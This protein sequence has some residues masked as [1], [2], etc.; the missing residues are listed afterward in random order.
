MDAVEDAHVPHAGP[1]SPTERCRYLLEAAEA[2]FRAGEIRASADLALE[3]SGLAIAM[4]RGDLAAAAA[5]VMPGV[6]DPSTA[7][8]VERMCRAALASADQADRGQRARIHA[9]LS[10][11]LHLR[12]RLDE[13]VDQADRAQVLADSIDDPGAF[14]AAL[15]A[16]LLAI[17][18]LGQAVEQLELSERMLD[19]AVAAASDD[20]ELQ[21]RIWRIDAVLR[22][23]RTTEAGHEV[24]SLDVLAARTGRPLVRWNARLARA[25]VDHALGRLHEAEA[26]ARAARAT[27]PASQRHQTE[28]LFI[29]QLMLIATDLAV[30]P[31]EIEGAR[32]A[33]IGAP[34]LAAA[35]TGRYDLS[36]RA[37]FEAVRPRLDEVRLDRRGLPTLT[38]A[39]ELAVAFG[40]VAVAES[41][42]ARLA[43]FDGLMIASTLGAVGPMAYFRSRLETLLGWHDDAIAHAEAAMDLAARGDFGPWLAR[44]R[45]ASAEALIA[46]GTAGD[47]ERAR[48]MATV[49]VVGARRLGM[50]ALADRADAL[51]TALDSAPNLSPREREIAG[52][53]ATGASNRAIADDLGISERTVEA[54]VQHILIKLDVH[55]RTQIATWAV[56]Q[57][58]G[59]ERPGT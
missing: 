4:D 18:G 1:G 41:L 20:A 14:A 45:L 15:N 57:G 55:S 7:A 38:A 21:A 27:L 28:P 49:A 5:L 56:G 3:A 39:A 37:S 19:A 30:E 32:A 40:D 50:G 58:I 11:A 13:A 44:A 9:Q 43:P 53:V 48:R 22:L 59:A 10:V 23:G 29:A 26:S 33:A 46:R 35:M 25:G 12:G 17:A 6:P 2:R 42:D 31:L 16:R 8:A 54:H 24:D 52:L 47:L 34:A 36:A 51:S